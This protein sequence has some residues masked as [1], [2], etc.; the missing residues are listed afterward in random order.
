MSIDQDP[1]LRRA[2]EKRAALLGRRGL[3]LRELLEEFAVAQSH[4]PIVRSAIV[5]VAITVRLLNH[6]LAPVADSPRRDELRAVRSHQ[7][8]LTRSDPGYPSELYVADGVLFQADGLTQHRHAEPIMRELGDPST[9]PASIRA[10]AWRIRVAARR[11]V[12]LA[13]GLLREAR[14]GDV[15]VPP[16]A[17]QSIYGIFLWASRMLLDADT[18][19]RT[20]EPR[21]AVVFATP[22][23]GPRALVCAAR[24]A[25]VPSVYFPHSAVLTDPTFNDLPTDFAG[26]RGPSEADYFR[27]IVED[28]ARVRV[29]GNASVFPHEPPGQDPSLPPVLAPPIEERLLREVVDVIGGEPAV[30]VSPH[31]LAEMSGDELR[32]VIPAGWRIWSGSTLEL[33]RRGAP[34]LIQQSSGVSLEAML[35]GIP[36][37]ELQ[38]SPGEPVNYPMIR[39]P[40]VRVVSTREDY[41]E[42]AKQYRRAADDPAARQRLLDWAQRWSHPLGSSAAQRA[43]ALIDEA[44]LGAPPGPIW[45]AWPATNG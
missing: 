44:G 23:V 28:D 2:R 17:V 15:W 6:T 27:E 22:N 36:V 26:V 3:E 18:L 9:P 41:A 32:A 10:P 34:F 43:A 14:A 16:G 40:Y 13:E 12:R 30:V 4:E 21:A 7:R 33:L 20:L 35:L 37:I 1:A 45:D 19:L 31:P 38:L 8:R 42:A 11:A 5:A 29:T 24:R 39:E 25:G